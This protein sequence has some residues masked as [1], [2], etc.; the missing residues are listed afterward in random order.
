M[1]K[2][3]IVSSEEDRGQS[4]KRAV[5]NLAGAAIGSII[6]LANEILAARFLGVSTYG[7]FAIGMMLT[8]LS[9]LISNFGM[10]VTVMHFI[11][12]YREQGERSKV[13]GTV[14][15][16]IALPLTIAIII[17]TALWLLA[18]IIAGE[19]FNEPA[20]TEFIRLLVLAIPLL[21][22]TEIIGQI[23]RSYG[24]AQYYVLIRN[25]IPPSAMA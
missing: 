4:R 7:L 15:A 19:I 10:P 9:E 16:A 17:A 12:L 23:T 11:P 14:L 24:F 5:I 8:K 20:A 6:T 22:L 1:E 25:I 21:S 18:P 13:V 2:S 3:A